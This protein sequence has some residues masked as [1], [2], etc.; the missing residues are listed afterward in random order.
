M[1]RARALRKT[2]RS[3]EVEVPVLRG[4]DLDIASGEFAALVGRSG[5][6]KTTL[7]NI[8]GGLDSDY[9]GTLEVDGQS[10]H[11]LGDAALADYR[12]RKVGFVFQSF[13][14][15][16]HMTC[17]EN[18]SLPALFSRG[19]AQSQAQLDSRS[20]QVLE[21]VGL[22]DKLDVY[23]AHLSGGQRQRVAIARALY[24]KPTLLVCD[25]PTGNLDAATGA[26]IMDIFRRLVA[27]EA[28]TLLI[29]THDPVVSA[30]AARI[31]EIDDGV[32]READR[33]GDRVPPSTQAESPTTTASSATPQAR[34][35]AA[36][37]SMEVAP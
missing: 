29:V 19:A 16:D 14:L 21:L 30:A 9:S 20:K 17:L 6:G 18:V 28:V 35:E 34:D 33:S 4:L 27:E 22:S 36:P 1:I 32:V 37:S 2:Y 12:N 3:R 13:H 11:G 15:L 5:A 8:I 24:H 10:L 25:E 26:T 31:I 7:L 23:P